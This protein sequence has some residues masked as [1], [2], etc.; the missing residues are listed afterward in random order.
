M[1]FSVQNNA[2]MRV[3]SPAACLWEEK[4]YSET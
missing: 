2:V 3:P 4:D 1:C